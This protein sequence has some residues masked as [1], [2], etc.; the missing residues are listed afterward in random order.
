LVEKIEKEKAKE[1]A[2]AILLSLFPF[3]CYGV[4]R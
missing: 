4:Q 3:L 2:E 1:A